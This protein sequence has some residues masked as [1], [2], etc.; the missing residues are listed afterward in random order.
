[1]PQEIL[2]LLTIPTGT[3][4]NDFSSRAGK[5]VKI[6]FLKPKEMPNQTIGGDRSRSMNIY[7][8]KDDRSLAAKT[9]IR[10]IGDLT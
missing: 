2:C 8:S 4:V 9:I 3:K 10:T 6:V 1:M 7:T 5:R